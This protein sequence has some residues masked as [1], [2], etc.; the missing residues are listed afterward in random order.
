[1]IF[2]ANNSQKKVP[3]FGLKQSSSFFSKNL[4]DDPKF[5][6]QSHGGALTARFSSRD[7]EET[8][9]GSYLG[10]VV[11]MGV[12][13]VLESGLGAKPDDLLVEGTALTAHVMGRL[14]VLPVPELPIEVAG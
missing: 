8:P 10:E 12:P 7:R 3:A 1:M 4:V 9:R 14:L 11:S 5:F 13:S 2:F 6:W